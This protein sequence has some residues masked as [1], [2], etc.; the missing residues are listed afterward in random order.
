MPKLPDQFPFAFLHFGR[1]NSATALG[2][3]PHRLCP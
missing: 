2:T 1:R 3:S